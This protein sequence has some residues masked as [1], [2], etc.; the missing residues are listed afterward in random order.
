[1]I[2]RSST[3]LPCSRGR[4][5]CCSCVTCWSRP[6]PRRLRPL[7]PAEAGNLWDTANPELGHPFRWRE[8]YVLNAGKPQFNGYAPT[9]PDEIHLGWVLVLPARTA[10]GPPAGIAGGTPV[11]A[12][13][14]SHTAPPANPAPATPAP[15]TQTP[16]SPAPATSL[17]A[18]PAPPNPVPQPT[19]GDPGNPS[20]S[21]GS[22]ASVP[23]PHPTGKQ[24]APQH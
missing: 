9:D 15:P 24:P 17:P 21:A 20:A 22:S 18:S 1:M 23:S 6:S 12:N 3:C 5:G 4:C 11:P 14:P 16:A 10:G 19:V 8:I 2:G 13:P 7:T